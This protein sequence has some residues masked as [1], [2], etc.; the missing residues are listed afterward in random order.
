[1]YDNNIYIKKNSFCKKVSIIKYYLKSDLYNVR[2]L[3]NNIVNS[4][5]ILKKYD[6]II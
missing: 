5:F 2:L 6:I 1:M 4:L 3:T